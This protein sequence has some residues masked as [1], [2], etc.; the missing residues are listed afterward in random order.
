MWSSPRRNQAQVIASMAFI[1][2]CTVIYFL[3]YCQFLIF[4]VSKKQPVHLKTRG[5]YL[6]ALNF[7][8]TN[9]CL[10]VAFASTHSEA[11]RMGFGPIWTHRTVNMPFSNTYK[12]LSAVFIVIGTSQVYCKNNRAPNGAKTYWLFNGKNDALLWFKS[13]LHIHLTIHNHH[14][15]RPIAQQHF[16]KFLISQVV[17]GIKR[18]CQRRLPHM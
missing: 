5:S 15:H 3:N 4:H 9:H 6:V 16:S 12:A 11:V 14:I 1:P 13:W 7:K 18:T 2:F 17:Q 8:G 10:L